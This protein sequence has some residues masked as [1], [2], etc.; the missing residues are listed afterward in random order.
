MIRKSHWRPDLD[1][2]YNQSIREFKCAQMRYP[3][4]KA[5]SFF[6]CVRLLPMLMEPSLSF[7]EQVRLLQSTALPVLLS[8][9]CNSGSKFH[10][11]L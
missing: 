9:K 6:K 8:Q 3:D 4:R 5:F 11:L 7:L 1:V 2:E 10:L